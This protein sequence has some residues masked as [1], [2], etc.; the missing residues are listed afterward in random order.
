[1][2]ALRD[3]ILTSIEPYDIRTL[4]ASLEEYGHDALPVMF[5]IIEL[6]GN[7]DVKTNTSN[8]ITRVKQ[9]WPEPN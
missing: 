1:M 6:S 7:P 2:K 5:E 8:S 9:R 3:K 4:L